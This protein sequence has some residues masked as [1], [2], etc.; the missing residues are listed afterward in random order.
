[1]SR[2]TIRT[3]LYGRPDKDG[4]V[5][6]DLIYTDLQ[7]RE[8]IAVF[9]AHPIETVKRLRHNIAH[10]YWFDKMRVRLAKEASDA[11]NTH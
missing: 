4:R 7:G 3:K 8:R 1:M 9:Y 11:K 6:H 2:V 10:Q 5:S